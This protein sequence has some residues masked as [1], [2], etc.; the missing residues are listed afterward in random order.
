MA[1]KDKITKI[2]IVRNKDKGTVLERYKKSFFHA[3]DGFIYAFKFEHNVIVILISALLTIIF[4]FIFH[5]SVLEWLFCII[6]IGMILATELINTSIEALVDLVTPEIHPL[7]K[8]AKDTASTAVL[9]L[10]TTALIGGLIIFIPK[11]I[12]I[13]I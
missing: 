3:I 10:C 8:I 7:A 1:L 2:K 9:I 12:G 4:G 5:L 13:L 11:I 6:I